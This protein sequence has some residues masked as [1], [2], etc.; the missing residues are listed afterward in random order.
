MKSLITYYSYSGN[1]DRAA[2]IF[3]DVLRQKGEVYIQRLMPKDE[4][5]QFFGQCRAAL[6]GKRAVLEE[7]VKF[8]ARDYDFILICSPVWA[9]R[10]TPAVNTYLDGL[11]GLN[12]KR[13]V[14]L[15]TSGSGAGVKR[16]FKNIRNILEAKGA[17]RVDEINIPDR[18]N[19][20]QN[21]VRASLEKVL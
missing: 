21:F 8:D 9:F 16:C 19:K 4:I 6:T 10:P 3:A 7:G 1:T 11:S 12:G 13:A 2:R 17:S 15:L 14:V 20:D 5:K 18:N